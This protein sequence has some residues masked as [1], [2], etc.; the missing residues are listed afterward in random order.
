MPLYSGRFCTIECVFL[1]L[2]LGVLFFFT[3][4]VLSQCGHR[5]WGHSGYALGFYLLTVG[6]PYSSKIFYSG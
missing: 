6:S 5:F 3:A 1:L 2:L 4:R